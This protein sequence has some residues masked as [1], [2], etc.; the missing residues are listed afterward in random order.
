MSIVALTNRVA[1]SLEVF[2]ERAF[3]RALL[4]REFIMDKQEA[5]DGLQDC[6]I[7]FNL[8]RRFGQDKIQEIMNEA[9][10]ADLPQLQGTVDDMVRQLELADPRDAW[11]HTG[12][13]PPPASVRNSDITPASTRPDY[14]KTPQSVVDAFWFVASLDDPARLAAWLA[15]HPRDERYLQKIWEQKCSTAAAK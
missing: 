8:V 7:A 2:R 14:Y 12:E 6:A 10:G 4:V 13:P 3:A 1:D 15:D 11:R 9:F 5:V